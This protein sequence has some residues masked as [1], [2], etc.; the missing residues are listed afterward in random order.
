MHDD[1]EVGCTE[2]LSKAIMSAANHEA[3]ILSRVIAPGKPE[4]P[5]QTA[6]MILALDFPPEDRERMNQLAENARPGVAR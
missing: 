6:E 4:L 5:R 3:D 1:L 2:N